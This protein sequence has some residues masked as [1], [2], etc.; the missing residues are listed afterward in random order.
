MATLNITTEKISLAPKMKFGIKYVIGAK[1]KSAKIGQTTISIIN[2]A[3]LLNIL[4]NI[5]LKFIEK[6]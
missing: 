5:F 6:L 4:L 2:N 1:I 3:S